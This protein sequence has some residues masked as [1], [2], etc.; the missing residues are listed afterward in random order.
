MKT[1]VI[2]GAD[3]MSVFA[4]LLLPHVREAMK[5]GEPVTAL[6]LTDGQFQK[7]FGHSGECGFVSVQVFLKGLSVGSKRSAGIAAG[8][9]KSHS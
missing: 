2:K 5:R 7:T 3:Q 1:G 6:G 9:A 8:Y 4:P